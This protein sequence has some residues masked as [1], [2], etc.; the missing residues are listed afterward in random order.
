MQLQLKTLKK[1]G[2]SA[3]YLLQIKKLADSL[4]TVGAPITDTEYTNAVLDG[5]F[6]EYHPFI[7]FVHLQTSFRFNPQAQ[8]SQQNSGNSTLPQALPPPSN[9]HNPKIMIANPSTLSDQSW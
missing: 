9:F 6:D 7:T 3:D 1:I 4:A 2:P 8:M 5:L